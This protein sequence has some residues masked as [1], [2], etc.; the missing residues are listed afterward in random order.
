MAA[1]RR[2]DVEAITVAVMTPVDELRAAAKLM[3]GRA[4]G[5]AVPLANGAWWVGSTGVF[6]G[7]GCIA[8]PVATVTERDEAPKI[9]EHIASWHPGVAS[10]VADWLE[11][12]ARIAAHAAERGYSTNEQTAMALAVARA[13]LKSGGQ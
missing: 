3:R 13:Y 1:D 10:A 8:D 12:M 4:W 5:A 11:V 7:C 9:A 2:E 6:A